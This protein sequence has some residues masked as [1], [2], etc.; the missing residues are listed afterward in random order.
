MEQ[1]NIIRLATNQPNSNLGFLPDYDIQ[2]KLYQMRT[3]LQRFR[4]ERDDAVASR[5]LCLLP[6]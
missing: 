2:N 6:K 3:N 5:A 1:L 4:Q